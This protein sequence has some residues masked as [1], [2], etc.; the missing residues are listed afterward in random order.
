MTQPIDTEKARADAVGAAEGKR[1]GRRLLTVRDLL[2]GSME[3]ATREEK[4]DYC[5]T[6]IYEIDDASGGIRPGFV[7]LIGGD[8]SVGKSSLLVQIADVNLER[9]RNV[10]IVSSEDAESLYGDRLMQRR[11]RVDAKHL[12]D[13]KLSL[14][15]A[16]RVRRVVERAERKPVYL[17]ARGRKAEWVAEQVENIIDEHNIDL[18][19]YDYIQEFRSSRQHGN[20]T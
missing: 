15:E 9:G 11:A 19:A 6:G 3:R 18:V 14:D 20:R 16:D 8:T 2:V 4:R 10:L 7:W 17:D 12:R 1:K 5:T 13:G